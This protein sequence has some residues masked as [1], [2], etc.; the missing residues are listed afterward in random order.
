MKVVSV[1]AV[2]AY[3][4]SKFLAPLILTSALDLVVFSFTLWPSYH[5]EKIPL[6]NEKEAGWNPEPVCTFL[7]EKYLFHLQGFEPRIVQPASA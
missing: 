1:H 4:D 6:T 7:E 3:R 2:E 5:R